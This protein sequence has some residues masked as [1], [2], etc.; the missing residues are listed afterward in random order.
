ML[1]KVNIYTSHDA[2]HKA[3]GQT[4]QTI[5]YTS[6]YAFDKFFVFNISTSNDAHH[7][8]STSLEHK[9]N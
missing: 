5:Y 9:A 4:T 6:D 3:V 8:K 2:L 7:R 1:T